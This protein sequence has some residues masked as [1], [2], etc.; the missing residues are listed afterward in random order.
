MKNK[1]EIQELIVRLN[2]YI[3]YWSVATDKDVKQEFKQLSIQTLYEIR[4]LKKYEQKS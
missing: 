4:S 1:E 2:T 3:E